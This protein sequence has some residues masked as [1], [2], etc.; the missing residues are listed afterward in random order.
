MGKVLVM[1]VS[2]VLLQ[3][4][5]TEQYLVVLVMAPRLAEQDLAAVEGSL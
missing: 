3:V 2:A 1:A 4:L 5:D